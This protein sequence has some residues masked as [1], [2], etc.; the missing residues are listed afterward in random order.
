MERVVSRQLATPYGQELTAEELDLVAGGEG[1]GDCMTEAGPTKLE[2]GG[3]VR[4]PR[5]LDCA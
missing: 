5:R 2:G 1:G 3:T 4:D